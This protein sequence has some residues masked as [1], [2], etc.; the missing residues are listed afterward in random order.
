MLLKFEQLPIGEILVY[1]VHELGDSV[2]GD[3][4]HESQLADLMRRGPGLLLQA[5]WRGFEKCVC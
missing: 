4:R 2:F 5:Q 1:L 3:S